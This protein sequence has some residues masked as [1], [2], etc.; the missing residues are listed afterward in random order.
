MV[1][2]GGKMLEQLKKQITQGIAECNS[3]EICA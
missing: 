1:M 2:K 3:S